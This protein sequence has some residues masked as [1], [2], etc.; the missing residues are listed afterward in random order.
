MA[1]IA[2]EKLKKIREIEL[3]IS[4]NLFI[5]CGTIT[6]IAMLMSIIKI[7]T[8]GSF[9]PPGMN[10]FYIGVL[11]MYSIHKEMLRWLEE[12]GLERRGEWF[13]YSWIGL[14]VILYIINFLSKGYFSYSAE[15]LPSESLR[16]ITFTTLEVCA[17]FVITR[18]SKVLKLISEKNNNQN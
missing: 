2:K 14:T 3:A 11:F 8:R 12:A 1:Q 16:E 6:V 15:G 13:V 10:I 9:P 5:I 7:F 17:I 18:L 4:K